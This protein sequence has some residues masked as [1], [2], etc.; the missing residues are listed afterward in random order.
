MISQVNTITIK[1]L[2]AKYCEHC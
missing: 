2:Y 1:Y